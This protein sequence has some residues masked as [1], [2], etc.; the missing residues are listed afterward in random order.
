MTNWNDINTTRPAINGNEMAKRAKAFGKRCGWK[1]NNGGWVYTTDGRCL[2][3][4]WVAVY[5]RNWRG[6]EAA[7]TQQ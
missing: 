3:Q 1:G 5:V 7:R 2:G 4:G 6:I